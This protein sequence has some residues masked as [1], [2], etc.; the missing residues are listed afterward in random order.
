MIASTTS[1]STNV[2]RT[3][4]LRRFQAHFPVPVL[5]H[6]HF[7]LHW[8]YR[9]SADLLHHAVGESLAGA[10]GQ[11]T[12]GGIL[13]VAAKEFGGGAAGGAVAQVG[14]HRGALGGIDFAIQVGGKAFG[15]SV[16]TVSA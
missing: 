16:S 5:R 4:P 7:F 2:N 10:V 1:N 13:L 9:H 11:Q 12:G 14:V 3:S 8:F 6:R 15:P